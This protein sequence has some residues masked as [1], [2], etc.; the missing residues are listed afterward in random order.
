MQMG[1]TDIAIVGGG[2]AGSTA[3]AMLGRAGISATVIDRRPDY[4]HDFRCE[5]LG[6][7]Q[8]DTIRKIGL[9]EVV[10]DASTLDDHVWTARFGRVVDKRPSDQHGVL[11]QDLVNAVRRAIPASVPAITATVT[12]IATSDDR[13]ALTL[14][15]GDI[16]SA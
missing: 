5:K 15:N 7:P 12:A 3:A 4:P 9:Y 13:Q 1:M 10:K 8:F 14:S 6:G 11:Y 16:I 2:L